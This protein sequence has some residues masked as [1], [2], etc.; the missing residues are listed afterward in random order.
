M[1]DEPV[2]GA[3]D[4][5]TLLGEDVAPL[6]GD[7]PLVL[8]RA[9]AITPGLLERRRAAEALPARDDNRLPT[10]NIPP[11]DPHAELSF[12]RPGIQ[13][14]VFKRLRHGEY[15]VETR[16]DLHGMNIEAAREAVHR[17][18]RDALK[19]DVRVCLVSH[20]RGA[21]RETPALLKSCVAHWLPRMEEVLAF[22]SAPHHLGGTGATLLLLRKS[23][24]ARQ[25]NFER[26]ARRGA[27]NR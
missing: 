5:G 4:F 16:L 19:H 8:K 3:D 26:Y 18:V 2:P 7:T 15:R 21:Q 9:P 27:A 20:G 25:E 23:E 1:N 11:V 14:G 6:A 17:L 24:R 12:V 22:H 13:H 10:T